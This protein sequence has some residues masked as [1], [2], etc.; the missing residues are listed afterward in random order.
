MLSPVR[1]AM[2][3][4][5]RKTFYDR[6]RGEPLVPASDHAL[7]PRHSVIWRVHGDVTTMIVG[8]IAALLT[9]MLHPQALG[10]VWDHSD[11][12]EDMIGRLR[13]TARFIAV[14]T[15]GEREAADQA[16]AKVKQIHAQVS[17]S[18]PDGTAYRADDPHLLAWV[19]VAGAL[20]FLEGWRRYGEPRMSRADQDRY[21][22]EAGKVALML[23]ADP[24]PATRAAAERL[25]RDFRSELCADTRTRAFRDL[26]LD[27]PAASLA[28]APVQRLLMGAAV[29]L[30]PG[31]ARDLHGLRRMP[32]SGLPIRAA[33]FGLAGTLRWAFARE[34]YR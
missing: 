20:M 34:A 28:E 25:V 16:I 31:W 30:L 6:S 8:G 17:G 7:F 21:F 14:T 5:V 1:R 27:A 4:Q 3:R 19:H 12:H 24:V 9:Q 26:V 18:L 29:D 2:V 33:T 32:M 13:R 22:A 23:G 15:Y 10:G 11:V